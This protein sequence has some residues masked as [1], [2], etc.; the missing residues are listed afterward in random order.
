MG[1]DDDIGLYLKIDGD[2]IRRVRVVGM[3]A[4]DLRSSKDHEPRLLGGEELLDIR[5]AREVELGVSSEDQIGEPQVPELPHDG[6][7]HKA[8]VARDKDLGR[9]FGEEGV[10]CCICH[11]EKD[12]DSKSGF[13]DWRSG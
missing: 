2:E 8:A 7:A 9:S 4:A 3:D 11:D 1:R 5:L 13:K 12:N 10:S 6:G